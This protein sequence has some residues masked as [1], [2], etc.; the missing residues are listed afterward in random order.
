M[1]QEYPDSGGFARYNNLI[2][3][4]QQHVIIVY[5]FRFLIRVCTGKHKSNTAWL[6]CAIN[7]VY[8]LVQTRI[9]KWNTYLKFSNLA[10]NF[11]VM[12]SALKAFCMY[13]TPTWVNGCNPMEFRTSERF[14]PVKL[15]MCMFSKLRNAVVLIRNSA[16]DLEIQEFSFFPRDLIF[17]SSISV[18]VSD[19]NSLSIL[20]IINFVDHDC[21]S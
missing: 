21:V 6:L 11:T 15:G 13:Q 5:V 17:R 19:E 1:E 9:I 3:Y 7:S 10:P 2:R 20:N 14:L 16:S 12:I 8:L 4:L 18:C